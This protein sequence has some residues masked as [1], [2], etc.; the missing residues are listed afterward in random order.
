MSDKL[1]LPIGAGIYPAPKYGFFNEPFRY[2]LE[3]AD[4]KIRPYIK[5]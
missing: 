4:S 1:L 2:T 3:P 5:S